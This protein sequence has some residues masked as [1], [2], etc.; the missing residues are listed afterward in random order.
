MVIVNHPR[1]DITPG[2]VFWNLTVLGS[3]FT[4]GKERGKRLPRRLKTLADHNFNGESP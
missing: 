3:A 2:N 4:I 1:I